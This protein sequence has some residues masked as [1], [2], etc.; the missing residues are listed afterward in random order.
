[1][2]PQEH[3]ERPAGFHLEPERLLGLLARILQGR[4]V[5]MRD[6]C[7]NRLTVQEPRSRAPP[8]DN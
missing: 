3:Q 7:I 1:M 6:A 8:A 5:E 4:E 2:I